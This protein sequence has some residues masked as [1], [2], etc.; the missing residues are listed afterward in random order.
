MEL[1]PTDISEIMEALKAAFRLIPNARGSELAR[2]AR[3]EFTFNNC[4]K[5]I[6]LDIQLLRKALSKFE[7]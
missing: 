3:D 7:N 1:T 4:E 5:Q 6:D 2:L